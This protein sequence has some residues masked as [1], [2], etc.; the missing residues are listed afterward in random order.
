M[1]LPLTS[2]CPMANASLARQA[3]GRLFCH[4]CARHIEEVSEMTPGQVEVL[5]TR[6]AAG[7]TMCVRYR[8]DAEGHVLFSRARAAASALLLVSAPALAD[9]HGERGGV[10]DVADALAAIAAE[11]AADNATRNEATHVERSPDAATDGPN[12]TDADTE[13]EQIYWGY[14]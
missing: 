5:K 9:G 7:D 3:D 13:V 2:P 12:D 6:K 8:A 1:K 4:D 14:Y 10:V 11:Q